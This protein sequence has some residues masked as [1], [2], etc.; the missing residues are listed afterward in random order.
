[1]ITTLVNEILGA[2]CE[3]RSVLIDVAWTVSI[4]TMTTDRCVRPTLRGS[5]LPW[6][7]CRHPTRR[8]A[9]IARWVAYICN[10]SFLLHVKY[11]LSYRIVLSTA[12]IVRLVCES[13]EYCR[14]IVSA[15]ERIQYRY[16]D[17]NF[18]VPKVRPFGV[19]LDLRRARLVLRW[20]TVF[21][22]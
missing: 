16:I 7:N 21:M 12:Q 5:V 14:F 19:G 3:V 10:L 13:V 4:W 6:Q 22:Q 20:V 8:S 11:T 2:I 9:N 1:M 17:I 18:V 15:S